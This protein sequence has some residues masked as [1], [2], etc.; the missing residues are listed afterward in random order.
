[1]YLILIINYYRML[2]VKFRPLNGRLLRL[3]NTQRE[4]MRNG[5]RPHNIKQRPDLSI[6]KILTNDVQFNNELWPIIRKELVECDLAIN[7]NNVD[8]TVVDT[9]ADA[10]N[11]EAALS[12]IKFVKKINNKLNVATSGKY[13]K[14]LHDR[15]IPLNDEEINDIF[16]LY[17]AIRAEYSILDALTAENCILALSLTRRWEECLELLEM[18][19]MSNPSRSVA[20]SAI[21]AA[22]F[23]NNNE[24]LGWKLVNEMLPRLKP[25]TNVYDAYLNYCKRNSKNPKQLEIHVDKIFNFWATFDIYP[26]LKIVNAFLN[27]LTS[28]GH[29]TYAR[30]GIEIEYVS[31]IYSLKI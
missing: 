5:A 28:S 30:T 7:N 18:L 9:F 14:L 6:N 22:A 15:E 31:L 25:Q 4:K 11:T 21:I 1:M 3:F 20:H 13:F 2:F 19:K 12:Y 24:K 26:D 23:N 27:D 10:K 29:W 16:E 8:S 17:D